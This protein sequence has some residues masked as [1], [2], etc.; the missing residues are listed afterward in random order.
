MRPVDSGGC[1]FFVFAGAPNHRFGTML[2]T[3]KK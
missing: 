3:C 2:L 1:F